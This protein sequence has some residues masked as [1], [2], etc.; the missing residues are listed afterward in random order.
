M[1][2]RRLAEL[3]GHE[4]AAEALEDLANRLVAGAAEAR[5]R[6][7]EVGSHEAAFVD[8]LVPRV[9][10]EDD[11]VDAIARFA[12]PDIYLVAAVLAGDRG[13]LA[14]F[15]RLVRAETTR[16]VARLGDATTAEDVVQ[17]LLVKLLVP[18]GARP[19]KLAAFGGHGA[20]HAWIRVAAVRTAISLGRRRQ[21][22]P[23]EDDALAAIADDSDDQALAFLKAS[24]RAEF[25][26]AFEATLA[27]MPR[28][29]RTLLRLQIIDHLTIEE[30][31]AFYQ[32]SRATAARW[33]AHA[34][35]ALVAGTQTRVVAALS[36]TPAELSELMRLVASS[37]YSTLPR[38][39]R[40]TETS[41]ITAS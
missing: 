31:G 22:S 5:A 4:L 1:H 41:A 12:L 3:T 29:S 20:L 2:A 36:I 7:P 35:T 23:I 30:I 8:A 19:A 6:W 21:E 9:E 33:L 27:E 34:R 28:R 17:E 16:A 18:S 26:Q 24:Y 38:L 14:A 37:L 11:V 15:E 25:K 32:I 10:G 40:R 39:L 13:A